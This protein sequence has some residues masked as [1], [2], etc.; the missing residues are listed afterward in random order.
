[1]YATFA[2]IVMTPRWAI[3]TTAL[4]PAPSLKTCP[5]I[6]YAPCAVLARISS[7]RSK[8]FSTIEEK[9]AVTAT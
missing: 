4:P 8:V 1:M 2:A 3:L 7:L 6:G 5:R 9:V